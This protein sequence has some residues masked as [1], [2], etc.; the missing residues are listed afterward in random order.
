MEKAPQVGIGGPGVIGLGL[1]AVN[2]V[3]VAPVVGVDLNARHAIGAT[4][5]WPR[6]VGPAVGSR[7]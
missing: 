2:N 6:I 1:L 4:Q 7:W 3:D 5:F